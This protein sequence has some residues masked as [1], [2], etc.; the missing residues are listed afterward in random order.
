MLNKRI[1]PA[2]AKRLAFWQAALEKSKSAYSPALLAMEQREA[3][4]SG[5]DRIDGPEKSA[6]KSASTVRNIVFELIE[7]QVDSTI[8][9]PRVTAKNPQD[10]PLALL[11]E[12][13]LKAQMDALPFEE[14]NDVDERNTY[15]QGGDFFLVEWDSTAHTHATSGGLCVSVRHPKQVIPQPGAVEVAK[16]DYFFLQFSVS[17]AEVLRRYGVQVEDEPGEEGPESEMVCQNTVYYKNE[18]GGIGRFSFVGDTVLEDEEDYQQRALVRCCNCG[19]PQAG[20]QCA[21]C[22]GKKF[23]KRPL[24]CEEL[25]EEVLLLSGEVVPASVTMPRPALDPLGAALKEG[26]GASVQLPVLQKNKVPYYKPKLF[27]L[28]LRRNVS[29]WGQLLGSSD[30]DVIRSQQNAIKKTGTKIE[31]KLLKGGSYV[32][33]PAGVKVDTSDAELKILRVRTPA[34]KALIDVVELQPDVSKDMMVLEQNYQWAKSTLGINDSFQG[35]ADGTAT[36]GTAKQFAAAQTA[37]RLESKRKMKNAAYQ[38]LY[39]LMFRF[40]L[41]YADE[42]LPIPCAGKEGEEAGKVFDRHLFL[43]R[44]AAGDLYWNDEFLFSVDASGGLAQ[45]REAM[46]A[47]AEKKFANGALGDVNDPATRILY[48]TLLEQLQYPLAKTIRGELVRAAKKKEEEP[49]NALPEMQM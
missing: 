49:A 4:Y 10:A 1:D 30:V 40:M 19:E 28:V 29:Q 17:R 25:Q 42:P 15:K 41:A 34:E 33:L 36:S 37:G 2:R 22:G 7:S 38:K 27:P 23:E 43:K 11:I 45:N 18:K 16:S 26:E 5:T 44:D 3:L 12:D 32:T 9:M 13:L 35:K 8:P 24:E 21:K 39:E 20:A 46:W 6:S 31:E 14:L 48:W 47:E